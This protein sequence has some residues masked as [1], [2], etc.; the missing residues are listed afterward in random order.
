MYSAPDHSVEYVDRL[1]VCANCPAAWSDH[2]VM[3]SDYPAL[4]VDGP[5]WSVRV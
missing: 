5:N 2:L 1:A 4:C 3:H